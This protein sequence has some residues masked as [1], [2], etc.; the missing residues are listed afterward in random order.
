MT[1]AGY[2][3]D[4]QAA[5]CQQP[6]APQKVEL[7][8]SLFH[9]SVGGPITNI[10]DTATTGDIDQNEDLVLMLCGAIGGVKTV[11]SE[12]PTT[13]VVERGKAETVSFRLW[14][15]AAKL[16]AATLRVLDVFDRMGAAG[17]DYSEWLVQRDG[18]HASLK[19]REG[20][21]VRFRREIQQ[22][23]RLAGL[24]FKRDRIP[25]ETQWE[26]FE[27]C[28]YRCVYCGADGGTPLTVD[29]IIPVSQ[30]GS[31]LAYNLQALCGPCNSR[32]C[33]RQFNSR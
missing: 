17:S 9:G 5:G 8:D 32:K 28:R 14:L 15:L 4:Q 2:R 18:W 7:E 10:M 31:S 24:E 26:V 30:G 16:E 20:D 6:A 27:A 22:M 1:R 25:R 3:G 11:V 12:I 13:T 29:H 23:R 19:E 21:L 33:D